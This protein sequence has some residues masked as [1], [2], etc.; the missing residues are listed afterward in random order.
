MINYSN[1]N[2]MTKTGDLIKK[3]RLEKGITQSRL[4]EILGVSEKTVGKWEQGVGNPD[5]SFLLPLANYF[6]I[7]TDELLTGKLNP[8]EDDISKSVFERIVLSGVSKLANY[9]E[10]GIDIFG[11]DEF[12]KTVIDYIYEHRNIEFLKYAIANNWYIKRPFK[13]SEK[14]RVARSSTNYLWKNGFIFYQK[15]LS[16]DDINNS[17]NTREINFDQILYSTS[18]YP[19]LDEKIYYFDNDLINILSIAI[20]NEDISILNEINYYQY[21][22]STNRVLRIFEPYSKKDNYDDEFMKEVVGKN[23]IYILSHLFHLGIK[24]NNK[25]FVYKLISFYQTNP[26]SMGTEYL[27]EMVIYNDDSLNK[28][29]ILSNDHFLKNVDIKTA[30]S[31]NKYIF[32]RL[33]EDYKRNNANE[34][35]DLIDDDKDIKE[36]LF[37]DPVHLIST[38]KTN[39]L[40]TYLSVGSEALNKINGFIEELVDLK[41]SKPSV[42]DFSKDVKNKFNSMF[43]NVFKYGYIDNGVGS[44]ESGWKVPMNDRKRLLEEFENSLKDYT[45]LLIIYNET[46]ESKIREVL[47]K[48]LVPT[49]I[50]EFDYDIAKIADDFLL[51]LIPYLD[52]ESRNLLLNCYNGENKLVL[53]ELLSH[54]AKF[55]INDIRI[56]SMKF[57]MLQQELRSPK[58]IEYDESNKKHLYDNKKTMN[59]KMMLG[60]ID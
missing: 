32:Y 38:N 60:V 34:I 56:S 5:I 46:P 15:H 59:Y 57:K 24:N 53:K 48:T 42:E 22:L 51:I 55:L 40:K 44:D 20:E 43:N 10:K 8:K 2:Y 3:L 52:M 21:F 19:M 30:Y 31:Q 36:L 16:E 13:V 9:L 14:I 17:D 45:R 35:V 23:D 47:Y 6:S 49:F 25:N 33:P 58:R 12:G 29:V 37:S 1:V 7:T 4:A 27:N 18:R 50:R 39:L 11:K 41:K 54:G 26:E 28:N